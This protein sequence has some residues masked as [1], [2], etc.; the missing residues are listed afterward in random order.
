MKITN[1]SDFNLI[2]QEVYTP[3][4]LKVSNHVFDK[5]SKE[6]EASSFRLNGLKIKA[7]KAKITPKK[8]GQFVTLWKRNMKGE[9]TPLEDSDQVDLV[10]INS[11]QGAHLGQFVFPKNILIQKGIVS[12]GKKSGKRGFR[13]YPPWTNPTSKTAQKNQKWQLEY[14]LTIDQNL[15]ID[16]HKARALYLLI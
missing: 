11:C 10:V 16:L 13:V 2:I 15:N 14:F 3:C 9:T 5:E 6:Y 8:I 12:H 1:N 7:R 4:G